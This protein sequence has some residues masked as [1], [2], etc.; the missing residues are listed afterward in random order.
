VVSYILQ[1]LYPCGKSPQFALNRKLSG[2]QTLS[3]HFGEEK[4][5]LCLL[6]VE[7][8]LCRQGHSLVTVLTVILASGFTCLARKYDMI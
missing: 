5:L 6:G 2:P 7:Q 8:F 1:L 4:D 3:G